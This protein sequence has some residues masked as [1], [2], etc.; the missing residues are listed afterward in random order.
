MAPQ[1]LFSSV[2]GTG[3]VAWISNALVKKNISSSPQEKVLENNSYIYVYVSVECCQ[4]EPGVQ[5]GSPN[6]QTKKQEG[7]ATANR[8]CNKMF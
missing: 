5:K 1:T 3:A 6:A 4:N 7:V 2:D 8:A